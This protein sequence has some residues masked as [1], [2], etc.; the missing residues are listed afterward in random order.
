[1]FSFY[2]LVVL[3][4]KVYNIPPKIAGSVTP[5]FCYLIVQ[6]SLLAN[7]KGTRNEETVEYYNKK[8]VGKR[9]KQA[10][11]GKGMTQTRLA[12][13]LDYTNERQLQRIENGETACPVDKLMEIVQ[14]LDTS[15][16]FILFGKEKEEKGTVS[17]FLEGKSDRQKQY[18]ER[19]LQVAADHL[20][21]LE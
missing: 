15:T 10:R 5:V 4:K 18:L 17:K 7:K 20:M 19:V 3:Y 13:C 8:A 21:L 6:Y 12:E 11:K 16:D 14:I 2:S 9:I 1:M